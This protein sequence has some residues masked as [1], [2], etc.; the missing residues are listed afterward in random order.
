V[1]VGVSSLATGLTLEQQAHRSGYCRKDVQGKLPPRN[2]ISSGKAEV[3][4]PLFDV[5]DVCR[6]ADKAKMRVPVCCSSDAGRYFMSLT[7]CVLI[8]NQ[9]CGLM[10]VPGVI[11]QHPV[12]LVFLI[13]IYH[14]L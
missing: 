2:E 14:R 12:V 5:E 11:F 3:I 8:R 4:Q 10:S 1:H 13:Y 6:E 7:H 9:T